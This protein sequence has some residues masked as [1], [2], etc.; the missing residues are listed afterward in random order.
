M[1]PNAQLFIGGLP[2]DIDDDDLRR[3]VDKHGRTS[4]CRI[5]RGDDGKSKSY[6]FV[7]FEV[8]NLCGF[9]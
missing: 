4:Y 7:G 5:V 6:A 1:R 3:F 9:A 2:P 8:R